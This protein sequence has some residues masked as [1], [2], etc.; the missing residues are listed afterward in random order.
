MSSAIKSVN[1]GSPVISKA[2]KPP[3]GSGKKVS[4]ASKDHFNPNE[5][6]LSS[7]KRRNSTARDKSG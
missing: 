4:S 2:S 5:S 7:F 1:I 6:F 3:I